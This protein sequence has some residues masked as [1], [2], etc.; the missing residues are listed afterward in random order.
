MPARDKPPLKLLQ[1][2]RARGLGGA[3]R[4]ICRTLAGICNPVFERDPAWDSFICITM[5]RRD[6]VRTASLSISSE[7]TSFERI[8]G[9]GA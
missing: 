5:Q 4:S 7:N 6:L 8:P 3:D 2:G 9:F 1:W